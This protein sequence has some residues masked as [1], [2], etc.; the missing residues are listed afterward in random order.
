MTKALILYG[1]SGVGKSE[2]AL[3]VCT[4][5]GYKHCDADAFKI[6]FSKERSKFRTYVGEKMSYLYGKELIKNGLSILIEAIPDMYN[7][8]LIQMLKKNK[9][10]ILEV[11]L[12]A[13]LEQCIRNNRM[14]KVKGYTDEVIAEVYNKLL[15]RR[16]K[17][18]DVTNKS[19][20]VVFKE[21]KKII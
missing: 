20:T 15:V 21:I 1:P 6:L 14:R 17:V 13:P 7:N 19:T 9:Y 5:Y 2:L 12:I 8:K 11:S 16:G 4:E 18:V 3:R 10:N